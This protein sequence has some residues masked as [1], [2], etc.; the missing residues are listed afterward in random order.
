MVAEIIS[1]DQTGQYVIGAN[2]HVALMPGVTLT[3]EATT[4]PGFLADHD[5][6]CTLTV[7]GSVVTFGS[8]AVIGNSSTGTM[9]A[10]VTVGEGGLL[11]SLTGFGVEMR[12]SGARID[13]DG[14]ISGGN[15]GV[16]F[17]AG[18]NG[19]ELAN[20]GTISSLL[21]NGVGVVGA[22]GGVTPSLFDIVNTG[23]IQAAVDGVSIASESLALTN[24]G[25]IIAAG[26][27]IRL[28]DDP[29][30]ENTLALVNTGLVQGGSTA[31]EATGHADS[32]TNS[33]T[34][35]GAVLLGDGHNVFDNSGTVSGAITAGAGADTFTNTGVASGA[36]DLGDGANAVTNSGRIENGIILGAGDDTVLSEGTIL[37]DIHL[38][39]GTNTATFAGAVHGSLTGGANKDIIEISGHLAGDVTLGNGADSLDIE[40]RIDGTVDMGTG[41]DTLRLG[42]TAR[43]TTGTLDG[44]S[45]DDT[46]LSRIDVEDAF[47]FEFINLKGASNLGVVADAADTLIYGN[48]GANEIDGG[49]GADVIYGRS[50]G[51]LLL[52]GLGADVLGGGRGADELVG[53]AGADR[54]NGGRGRD[55]F[56]YEATT[57]SRRGAAD[58]I[59][60][61]DRGRDTLD[62]TDLVEGT[63]TWLGDD[64]FSRS[65]D[66][67]ARF[68]ARVD[69]VEVRVDVDGDGIID[70]QIILDDIARLTAGD[71]HL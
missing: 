40:G 18:A 67:E 6:I 14:V 52:G 46:L 53:G 23:T 60:D 7:L 27:G 34:L 62:L 1:T 21:G 51:D 41:T 3:V 31:V 4:A 9:L 35:L 26:T 63:I 48:R 36:I 47:N 49:D 54:L 10:A 64:R 55:V 43:T 20:S 5:S 19:A 28:T 71:F 65:G 22:A 29:A 58:R 15:A 59:L 68:K 44:G 12:R 13:N 39:D 37:G 8:A 69:S 66:A 30:L 61:F 25:D 42:A 32:V 57:D 33:G 45:G 50:G 11:H 38:G 70:T 17:A 16:Q 24:H 2:A 56:V